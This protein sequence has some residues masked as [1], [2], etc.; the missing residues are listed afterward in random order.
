MK[1]V[2]VIGCCGAGK[3]TF[4]RALHRL[5]GLE[6]IHLDQ[7][8]WKPG[9]VESRK[10]DWA[11]VVTKLADKPSWII[12]GNY[13][14]TMEIRFAKA[15]TIIYMDFPTW[16][17]LWRVFKRNLKYWRIERPDMPKGCKERFSLKFYHYVA[18]YN[19]LRR[20]KLLENLDRLRT[21]KQ[22]YVLKNDQQALAL[23]KEIENRSLSR[24]G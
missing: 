24:V 11:E 22:I 12:D 15:D 18:T 3:S 8:F 2:M 16:K 4:S 10:E 19:L 17:C 6:L 21:N 5:T 9:W 13:G 23:L 1:R 14:G 20:K 7:H